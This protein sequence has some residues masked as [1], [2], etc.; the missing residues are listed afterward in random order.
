MNSKDLG[1]GGVHGSSVTGLH[2]AAGPI[3]HLLWVAQDVGYG[4]FFTEIDVDV[5]P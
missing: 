4:T 1:L 3:R 2:E 5:A